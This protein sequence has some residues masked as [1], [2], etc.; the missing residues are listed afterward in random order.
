[1]LSPPLTPGGLSTS[2]VGPWARAS[3]CCRQA[4]GTRSGARTRGARN[5]LPRGHGLMRRPTPRPAPG[6]RTA[7]DPVPG[8]IPIAREIAGRNIGCPGLSQMSR[9][10]PQAPIL[11]PVLRSSRHDSGRSGLNGRRRH[12]PDSYVDRISPARECRCGPT[13]QGGE[14]PI[15]PRSLLVP[16]VRIVGQHCCLVVP[17]AVLLAFALSAR[18]CSEPARS[19]RAAHRR[20]DLRLRTSSTKRSSGRSTGSRT[21]RPT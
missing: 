9:M 5:A 4:E 17:V 8:R 12:E 15:V 21:A 11:R 19:P 18:G 13:R 3:R 14:S 1:M 20:A 10:C 7:D 2:T 16:T 6:R